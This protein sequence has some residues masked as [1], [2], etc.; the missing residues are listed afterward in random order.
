MILKLV[1]ALAYMIDAI[2]PL[3]RGFLY[4]GTRVH[5]AVPENFKPMTTQWNQHVCTLARAICE[6]LQV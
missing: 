6:N 5:G 2:D 4:V 1:S 3:L